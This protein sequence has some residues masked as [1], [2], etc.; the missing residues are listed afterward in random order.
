MK[1]EYPTN[2][3][4][5]LT[6]S[7]HWEGDDGWCSL[8]Q[9][10]GVFAITDGS[11]TSVFSFGAKGLRQLKTLDKVAVVGPV[12]GVSDDETGQLVALAMA[13]PEAIQIQLMDPASG[14]VQPAVSIAGYTAAER[15]ESQLLLVHE[16]RSGEHRAVISAADH[17]LV[18]IQSSK[19]TWVR[20]EG[21]ATIQQA[22]LY[23]RHTQADK[24]SED[25][26]LGAQLANLPVHLAELLKAPFEILTYLSSVIM[27]RRQRKETG[28]LLLP[29]ATA[30]EVKTKCYTEKCDVYS[31][32]I[33]FINLVTGKHYWQLSE[34]GETAEAPHTPPPPEDLLDEKT[35]R[36][37]E[38]RM[39]GLDFAK[40]MIQSP[41][42]Q[43][44]SAEEAL[45]S[46]W[47]RG[48]QNGCPTRRIFCNAGMLRDF[49]ADKLILAMSH[50]PKIFALQAT[51][52]EV[53]WTKY[54]GP[55]DPS[56][57]GGPRGSHMDPCVP[58]MQL[59]P[60]AA[61]PH[62]ELVVITPAMA[63][64]QKVLWMDPLTGAV[65]HE[66]P[67][68]KIEISA[69][70]SDGILTGR[71]QEEAAGHLFHY[72]VD[73]K[74]Q[75]VQ[76]FAVPKD[77]SKRP[78]KLVPIWNMEFGSLGERI[79]TA[80]REPWKTVL[81]PMRYE[82]FGFCC[83]KVPVFV[84]QRKTWEKYVEHTPKLKAA[85]NEEYE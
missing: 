48:K 52:S 7:V 77:G 11:T 61:S 18:G 31:M 65:L 71:L 73:T 2:P 45:E 67:M 26:S 37:T 63:G 38:F 79:L 55:L 39:Q 27:A 34:H 64:Q 25:R 44:L 40:E 60:S 50:A 17:S 19:V 85:N 59:L 84:R 6:P 81:W 20:E 46:F 35:W 24:R 13:K 47:L 12:L 51:T 28:L 8:R 9:T 32:G 82:R 53:V 58:W 56:C 29:D 72:E 36:G 5:L 1:T 80:V 4:H 83:H 70:W 43:R 10:R 57:A 74:N 21:L 69:A 78:S 14:N 42:A 62:A 16:L 3:S 22:D 76:G 23:S 66:E 49:G 15:G 54:L 33:L 68:P 75:V 30:P 41:E